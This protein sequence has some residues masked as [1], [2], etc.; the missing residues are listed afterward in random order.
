VY[1]D[2][3]ITVVN[4]NNTVIKFTPDDIVLDYVKEVGE[5]DVVV[6]YK[7]NDAYKSAVA[8]TRIVIVAPTPS[9]SLGTPAIIGIV[10]AV[11]AVA[12]VIGFIVY[13]KKHKG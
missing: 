3:S 4:E 9:N 11:A 8:T 12:G 7:G 10:L 2:L 5:Q 13:R 6:K 1:R